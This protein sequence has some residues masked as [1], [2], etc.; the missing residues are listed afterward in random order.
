MGHKD[1]NFYHGLATEMGFGEQADAVQ[2]A[3]LDRRYDDAAAALP[4][5][6]L[7]AIALL[8]SKE[9]IAERL[10]AYAEIGVDTINVMVRHPDIEM[11]K[12]Q[13]RALVEAAELSGVIQ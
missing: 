10:E 9:R 11:C 13:L 5:E 12:A 7:D 4:L 6:L 3:Y 8:G 1:K 2:E